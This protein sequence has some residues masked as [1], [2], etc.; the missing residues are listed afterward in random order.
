LVALE[1]DQNVGEEVTSR[2]TGEAVAL[3]DAVA[4]AWATFGSEGADRRGVLVDL[5][6]GRLASHE[7]A[8]LAGE[9][10]YSVWSKQAEEP[11]V[12]MRQAIAWLSRRGA[13]S[14]GDL[15]SLRVAAVD[16]ASLLVRLAANV[17]A[18]GR[19]GEAPEARSPALDATLGALTAEL[20]ARAR[21]VE[22]PVD[23][24][25][26]VVARHLAG[27]LR[28][29]VSQEPL[30]GLSAASPDQP[31]DENV[32]DGLRDAWVR[33]ATDE[34]VAVAALDSQLENPSYDGRFD[35]L[36]TAIAEGAANVIC[37]ARLLGRPAAFRHRRA[38]R[39][40]AV[41]LTYALEAY[42]AGLRG[43]APSLA[44]SQRIALTRLVRAT[45]A[46]ALI[47]LAR[48]KERSGTGAP[49]H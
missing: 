48:A 4:R 7:D 11:A 46:I 15:L 35:S 33:L 27:A 3:L 12:R 16:V 49:G 6:R 40:Q 17:G 42:V 9:V 43:D 5:L 37:G 39:H 8:V 45:V 31:V 32:L 25:A 41:A 28:V 19:A 23:T 21:E 10:T 2:L 13:T 18:G 30:V 1:G 29:R 34:Y 36:S 22:R 24:R 20:E 38:W 26:D 44:Q 47:D 14:E